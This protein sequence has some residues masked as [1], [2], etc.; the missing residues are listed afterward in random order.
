M[1]DTRLPGLIAQR[2]RRHFAARLTLLA[3]EQDFLVLL[4]LF[5][6]FRAM[7][8]LAFRPGGLILDFSD[9]SD[10]YFALVRLT[11]QGYYPYINLW[12]PYPPLISWPMIALYKVSS[13]LP[14]WET[15][16]LWFA[17][18]LG[19][20]Y[21]LFETGNLILV[22]ALARRLVGGTTALRSAWFYSLLFVPV[23][24]L[25]GWFESFPIFFFLL[26]IYLLVR[27]RLAWSGLACGVGFM[28]RLFPA[29]LLP[30]GIRV[31]GAAG[32]AATRRPAGRSGRRCIRIPRLSIEIDLEPVLLYLAAFLL[33]VLAI[34]APLWLINPRLALSPLLLAGARPPWETVWALLAGNFGYGTLPLDQRN[35]AWQPE[36]SLYFSP[37]WLGVTLALGLLYL[38]AYTRRADWQHPRSVVAFAGFTLMLLFLVSKGYSPQWLGWALVLI[39]ILL[40]NL[41]GAFYALVLSL[42][43]LIEANVFFIIVPDEHWLLMTTVGLR[44]LMLLLLTGE[45][46]L[47]VQ[48]GWLRS[49]LANA[50]RWVLVGLAGALLVGCLPAGARFFNAY[51][52]VRHQLSPYRATID[53]L[54]AEAEPGAALVIASDDHTSYD[55]L[56]PYLRHR[57]SFYMLDDYA[58]PGLSVKARTL[59]LLERIAAAHREWWLFDSN[60][61]TQSA[62]EQATAG[63]LSEYATLVDVRDSDKGRLYHFRLKP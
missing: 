29:I 14:P 55:W 6:A 15:P 8:I 25:T 19:S 57:L 38:F 47:L 7:A 61:T 49:W 4:G 51:F 31:A 10:A 11:R 56:Y 48:P 46:I 5:V 63:W 36:T 9:Y 42:A 32:Y 41:R 26:S 53:T 58:P 2:L 54:R 3:A 45:F 30:L 13:L 43:N 16:S 33:P 28:S 34:G 62:S 50:R 17:L 27:N 22:Y 40:P 44:T 20:T 35:L 39:A 21:L 52:E 23:Y 12:D 60:P 24:T 37:L 59:A 18:L 1:R